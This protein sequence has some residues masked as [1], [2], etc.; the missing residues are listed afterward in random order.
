MKENKALERFQ[1]RAEVWDVLCDV[2]G[3][4]RKRK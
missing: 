1:A 3:S 2:G 4:V